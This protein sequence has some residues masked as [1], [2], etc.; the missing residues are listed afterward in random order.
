[1]TP[2]QIAARW[3]E[4]FN[5]HD[6][7]A[8]VGLYAE[9]AVHHSPKL[10]AARPETQG[11]IAGQAALTEWWR[12]AF[13]RLPSL[14]YELQTVTA[15]AARVLIVY[16]RHVAGEADLLVAECFT[17]RDGLIAASRVFHG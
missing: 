15:D 4:A 14:H 2:A 9:D 8:L 1:M 10:R 3:I 13:A 11:R 17:V 16:E 5:R 7:V 6:V 12:D